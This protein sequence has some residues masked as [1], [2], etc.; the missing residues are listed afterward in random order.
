MAFRSGPPR[1]LPQPPQPPKLRNRPF[2]SLDQTFETLLR[3]GRT[4]SDNLSIST[5]T[6][7]LRFYPVS[8]M[9]SPFIRSLSTCQR[10]EIHNSLP[11]FHLGQSIPNI[12]EI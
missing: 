2:Q 4:L 1:K 3:W 5:T 7:G 9:L 8:M 11:P 12:P 6:T 10:H